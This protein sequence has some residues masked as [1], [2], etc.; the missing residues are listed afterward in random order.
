MFDA[1]AQAALRQDGV[2]VRQTQCLGVCTRVCTVA[3]SGRDAY[4]FLLGDLDPASHAEA[5]VTMACACAASPH[6]FVPWKERPEPLR[7]AM[8]ARIP[9]PGWSPTDGGTPS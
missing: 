6:G 9:P 1:V 2:L 8:L 7:N 3:I 4:T 5:V